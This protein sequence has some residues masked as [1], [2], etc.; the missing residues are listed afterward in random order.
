[1]SAAARFMPGFIPEVTLRRN[2]EYRQGSQGRI[3]KIR[4]SGASLQE[5]GPYSRIILR[6]AGIT[7][8]L[9]LL[10]MTRHLRT[11]SGLM[12]NGFMS[13]MHLFS[14][15]DYGRF[16]AGPKYCTVLLDTLI[17]SFES[18]PGGETGEFRCYTHST[19]HSLRQILL[20]PAIETTTCS[21]QQ[22]HSFELSRTLQLFV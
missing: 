2:F 1:M 5:L 21:R 8:V 13:M 4:S 20:T 18:F 9:L 10:V 7:N 22:Q 14:M 16:L 17:L 11:G 12:C 15:I 3:H 6:S 19:R